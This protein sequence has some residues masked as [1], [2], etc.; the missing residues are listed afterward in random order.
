M[1][2]TVKSQKGCGYE[3]GV[4]ESHNCEARG[5]EGRGYEDGGY[6]DSDS[7]TTHRRLWGRPY[8]A[9]IHKTYCFGHKYWIL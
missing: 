4:Y 7:E 3:G 8:A 6:K 1:R 5:Y 9:I 2:A